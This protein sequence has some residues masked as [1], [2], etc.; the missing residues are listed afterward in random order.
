MITFVQPMPIGNAVRVLFAPPDD[1]V[2]WKILRKTS[3]TFSGHA[4]PDAGVVYDGDENSV[5][6]VA[7][8]INGTAYYY[9]PYYMDASDQWSTDVSVTCTPSPTAALRGPDPQALVRERLELGL[10]VEVEA[11]RLMHDNGYVPCLTAPPTFEGTKF[12]IVTVRVESL[13]RAE[14]GVGEMVASDEYDVAS[15]DWTESEGFLARVQLQIGTWVVGN[16]D[17]RNALR[18][19]VIK[20]LLGNIPVFYDQGLSMVEVSQ[21]DLEDFETY[22]TAMFQTVSTFTCLAPIAVDALTP[23]IRDVAL[24]A[25]A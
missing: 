2:A 4:D 5:I 10:R 14:S 25:T 6:D 19:A 12:P 3:D 13:S 7:G 21:S 11:G 1:A 8:L 17:V 16:V 9:K 20:V 24:A 22:E 18:K 23:P 15:D